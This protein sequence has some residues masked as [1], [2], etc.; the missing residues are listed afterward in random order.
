MV[1]ATRP[2]NPKNIVGWDDL[3]RD[4]VSVITPNPFT[5]GGAMWNIMAAYGAQIND[6]TS[7]DARYAAANIALRM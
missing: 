6:L 4:D 5:S 7:R 2:G 3:I 1:L